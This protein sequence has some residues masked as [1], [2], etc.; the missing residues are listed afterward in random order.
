MISPA[1]SGMSALV[2]PSPVMIAG[3]V[4]ASVGTTA[5]L[6]LLRR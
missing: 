2:L 3:F 6:L 5:T 1:M 4:V